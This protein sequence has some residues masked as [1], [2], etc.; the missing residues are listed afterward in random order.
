MYCFI[1][2]H[3]DY[4]NMQVKNQLKSSKTFIIFCVCLHVLETQLNMY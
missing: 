4:S 2:A 1:I 3:I